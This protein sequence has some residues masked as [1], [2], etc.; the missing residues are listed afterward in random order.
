[1]EAVRRGPRAGAI[2][3]LCAGFF[4]MVICAL[5]AGW[6]VS[7][8]GEAAFQRSVAVAE[9]SIRQ[10]FSLLEL[11]LEKQASIL[12]EVGRSERAVSRWLYGGPSPVQGIVARAWLS[13]KPTDPVLIARPDGS[14]IVRYGLPPARKL[15]GYLQESDP[16]TGRLEIVDSD[17]GLGAASRGGGKLHTILKPVLADLPPNASNSYSE[18]QTELVGFLAVVVDFALLMNIDQSQEQ[19]VASRVDHAIIA[20]RDHHS[21]IYTP[22]AGAV[23]A[24]SSVLDD[25]SGM[26]YDTFLATFL[27]RERVSEIFVG[28]YPVTVSFALVAGSTTKAI[29]FTVLL[30]GGVALIW[31]MA[32]VY[33]ALETRRHNRELFNALRLAETSMEAKS[34]FLATMSHEIRTPMNGII[35]MAKLLLKTELD[36]RQER[37]AATL[38]RSAKS[39]LNVLND[40]LH[41]SKIEA[42]KLDL[43]PHDIDLGTVL[44][45]VV[46][47]HGPVAEGKGLE[48]VIDYDPTKVGVVRMDETRFRQIL[49]NLIGNAIKFTTEGHIAVTL[50]LE[51]LTEGDSTI[52]VD[53][54]DSGIGM[55]EAEVARVFDE[56]TQAN[57]STSRTYGGTGLGL[58]ISRKLAR[59]MGGDLSVSSRS[60]TGS[61]FQV[62]LPATDHRRPDIDHEMPEILRGRTMAVAGL[63]SHTLS[64]LRRFAAG[65]GIT[66]VDAE[67]EEAGGSA[68]V[69]VGSPCDVFAVHD[70]LVTED[71]VAAVLDG[72]S[73]AIWKSAPRFLTI[74]PSQ[75]EPGMI[76]LY[77]ATRVLHTPAT[78]VA[79]RDTLLSLFG[80]T[81]A[82]ESRQEATRTPDADAVRGLRVLMAE[83]DM[84][85]RLYAAETL[86]EL[87]CDL[88]MVENGEEAVRAVEAE[89]FDVVLMDC[90]M[91]VMDGYTAT[92]A[93]RRREET[94]RLPHLPIVALTANAMHGDKE[95]C[96]DAGMDAF[97]TKPIDEAA[98]LQTLLAYAEARAEAAPTPAVQPAATPEAA[99]SEPKSMP[100]P[101][102]QVEPAPLRAVAPPKTEQQA[103]KSPE[104][105]AAA[106]AAGS[107]D[108][109]AAT[110]AAAAID[111]SVFQDNKRKMG[112]RF[113][114]LV[115]AYLE[116]SFKYKSAILEGAAN[117]NWEAVSISAHTLKSSSRLVGAAQLSDLAAGIERHAKSLQAG[118]HA[119]PVPDD[120]ETLLRGVDPMYQAVHSALKQ[121]MA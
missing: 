32:S 20:L 118:A 82:P 47:L 35:G 59:M 14:S 113:P 58:A 97:L 70:A 24:A 90:M 7:H 95:K 101:V 119:G 103:P 92:R 5:L 8:S 110:D 107:S 34:R 4:L 65:L 22:K 86:K 68:T 6:V 23:H 44:R 39:L 33:F 46:A 109:P 31:V 11:D 3:V 50:R 96:F 17:L 38:S 87:G 66:V 117:Q 99:P 25:L 18:R 114:L 81:V 45:D 37:Y 116:D 94:G 78:P 79:L 105:P 102:V 13:E 91:P 62:R 55:S 12:S 104:P 2:L 64:A 100:T 63:E 41:Y 51:D 83:D 57:S 29:Y 111:P 73:T 74:V 30:M 9:K 76:A 15:M 67:V 36:P 53:I 75:S 61:V 112:D 52:V 93:I 27:A 80:A 28:D 88:T 21:I 10:N 77:G 16:L 26:F 71:L 98:L 72:P 120:L 56:F 84:V 89:R 85:N 60:G 40:V 106:G 43:N 54:E 108:G 48:F 69:S 115:T 19:I 49:N 42:G 1:M 121:G